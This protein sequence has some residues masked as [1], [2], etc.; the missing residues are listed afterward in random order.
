MAPRARL[1]AIAAVCWLITLAA[2]AR[3]M[4]EHSVTVKNFSFTD[5]DSGTS[6]TLIPEGD[7]VKWHWTGPGTDHSVT[8]DDGASFDSETVKPHASH[9]AGDTFTVVFPTSGC[10]QY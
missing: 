9:V 7:S 2:A 3:A 6:T 1:V 10:F 4:N 8:S 5:A